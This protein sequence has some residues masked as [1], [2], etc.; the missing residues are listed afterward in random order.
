ME[1]GVDVTRPLYNKIILIYS[2][3]HSKLK[4]TEH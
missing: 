3:G 2:L 1:D 4:L